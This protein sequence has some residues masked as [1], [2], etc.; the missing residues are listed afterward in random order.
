MF[1]RISDNCVVNSDYLLSARIDNF[2]TST[3]S[4][5]LIINVGTPNGEIK[6][7]QVRFETV[8]EAELALDK[9]MEYEN[10]SPV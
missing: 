8:K 3:P 1:I 10:I 4:C 5:Y 6:T 2:D 9:L 7:D